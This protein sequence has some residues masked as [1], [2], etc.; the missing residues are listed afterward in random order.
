MQSD[1]PHSLVL[2]TSPAGSSH[3]GGCGLDTR[4]GG[5]WPR[6]KA[7]SSHGE[8]QLQ[9]VGEAGPGRPHAAHGPKELLQTNSLNNTGGNSAWGVGEGAGRDPDRTAPFRAHPGEMRARGCGRGQF[10]THVAWPC[11]ALKTRVF[12]AAVSCAEARAFILSC[13]IFHPFPVLSF[14]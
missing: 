9:A 10:V 11:P 6:P 2:E 7:T 13:P 3:H 14:A 12:E 5:S 4:Q 1:F 8:K